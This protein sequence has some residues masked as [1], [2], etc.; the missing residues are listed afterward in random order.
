MKIT[1]RQLR[2]LILR[3]MAYGGKLGGIHSGGHSDRTDLLFPG[4]GDP[5]EWKAKQLRAAGAYAGSDAFDVE[6]KKRFRHLEPKIHVIY[7]AGSTYQMQQQ[8]GLED[9]KL[10]GDRVGSTPDKSLAGVDASRER[11]RI[12]SLEQGFDSIKKHP[13]LSAIDVSGVGPDDVVILYS[14]SLV[15]SR[16][17]WQKA[18]PWII[19][20][21]IFEQDVEEAEYIDF[22]L[23]K[24]SP[25]YF[26]FLEQLL[27]GSPHNR[28]SNKGKVMTMASARAGF[29]GDGYGIYGDS[30]AE[31]LCQ[32]LLVGHGLRLNMSAADPD[33]VPLW[34]EIRQVIK[35]SAQEVRANLPGKFI[36]VGVN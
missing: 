18:T 34:E 22:D 9:L 4:G 2:R 13:K 1:R 10:S 15:G 36:V 7:N 27:L 20:H 25:T 21:A 26:K 32:E 35:T 6:A 3:E 16:S 19:F 17:N 30:L 14:A 24:L 11:T 5:E 31:M 29:F 12:V 28:I 8:G 33:E 23:E